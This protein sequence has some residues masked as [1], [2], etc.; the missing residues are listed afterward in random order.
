MWV[1]SVKEKVRIASAGHVAPPSQPSVQERNGH[2]EGAGVLEASLMERVG[3][4]GGV[5]VRSASAGGRLGEMGKVG[6]T[7]RLFRRG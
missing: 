1:E 4:N 2:G 6:S 5:G 3:G 7:K